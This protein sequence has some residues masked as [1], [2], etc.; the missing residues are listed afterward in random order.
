VLSWLSVIA[1]A[2]KVAGKPL[3]TVESIV[4]DHWK[5]CVRRVPPP[6]PPPP[7]TP[8]THPDPRYGRNYYVRW[9][10]EGMPAD[11]AKGMV[12]AMVDAIPANT[13][14]KVGNYTIKTADMFE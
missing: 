2:N 7:P 10:F 13:G 3:V 1:A 14:R 12:A 11:G 8:L 4:T 5:K 9:D 6:P